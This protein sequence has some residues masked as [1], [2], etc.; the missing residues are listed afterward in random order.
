V[1]HA[2]VYAVACIIA[3][4]AKRAM[5]ANEKEKMDAED[6]EGAA[7]ARERVWK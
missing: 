6:A 1:D 7:A 2:S 3:K 5:V 4:S